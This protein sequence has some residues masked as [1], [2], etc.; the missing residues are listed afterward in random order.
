MRTVRFASLLP[1]LALAAFSAFTAAPAAAQINVTI[2]EFYD[3]P[4]FDVTDGV[5]D[6]DNLTPGNQITLRAAFMHANFNGGNWK[7][8]LPAGTY[9][10]SLT[11]AGEDSALAGDLDANAITA[12][13]ECGFGIAIIDAAVLGDRAF[14][15]LGGGTFTLDRVT[16]RNATSVGG[17]ALRQESGT[18]LSVENAK[19]ENC[20]ATG[21]VATHGGGI[22]SFGRL[23]MNNSIVSGCLADGSGG[24]I[25]FAGTSMQLTGCTV[26]LNSAGG[27]GGGIDI[28]NAAS[29]ATLS[30]TSVSNNRSGLGIGGG[31]GGGISN[32][33][34]VSLSNSA[35]QYNLTNP[36]ASGGGIETRGSVAALHSFIA[37]NQSSLGGGLLVAGSGTAKLTDCTV[38]T[39][40][41]EIGGGAYNAGTLEFQHSTIH[42]NQAVI[43]AGIAGGGGIYSFATLY[44]VNST[45]SGNQAVSSHGGGL[46][47][48]SSG[49]A[50]I[51]SCT[52][53]NNLAPA[54]GVSIYNGDIGFTPK[55][56]LRNT[57][58]SNFPPSPGSPNYFDPSGIGILSDGHNYDT[59]DTFFPLAPSDLSPANGASPDPYLGPL[60][61]NGGPT[62]THRLYFASDAIGA[63]NPGGT[64]DHT[65][66]TLL[67][68]QRYEA[69]PNVNTADIGAYEARCDADL[70]PPPL[71]DGYVDDFD[72]VEFAA[73]Y[74]ILVTTLADFNG[75][76]YTDDT[77]FIVFAAAYNLL[78]CE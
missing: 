78:V 74:N 42:D 24:G 61:F 45:I 27:R 33:G 22:L 58:L 15:V 37:D 48:A 21:S 71:G 9:T 3:A 35:V 77:D 5:I 40:L 46:Y 73:A 16:V 25:H 68:D 56:F 39:N 59:D 66:V 51:S 62:M 44:L 54:G 2:N 47:N 30:F 65:G 29:T 26:F 36:G 49:Y 70:Y 28:A 20:S 34:S 43:P 64:I 60:Q 50:E 63:A 23:A 4:D 8:Q 32:L 17:G 11:G 12:E 14:H 67:Q 13:V 72:F 10:L 57:I 7:F 1:A 52:F 19:I 41:A 38:S 18:H 76:G 53:H 6:A 75:D 31:S 69:R 55:V